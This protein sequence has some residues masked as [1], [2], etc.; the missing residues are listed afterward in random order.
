MHGA[1]RRRVAREGMRRRK[2][3]C[4]RASWCGPGTSCL[5]ARITR[6]LCPGDGPGLY[7]LLDNDLDRR[8]GWIRASACTRTH[9]AF[10][11]DE[12]FV[13]VFSLA[14]V[15]VVARY[16]IDERQHR[17][18]FFSLH[19]CCRGGTVFWS[20]SGSTRLIISY[21]ERVRGN[22]DGRLPRFFFIS[23]SDVPFGFSLR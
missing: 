2:A 12:T 11:Y 10:G 1:V 13:F 7:F 16:I 9:V 6:I 17:E 20:N 8:M 18:F 21:C 23:L 5:S 15:G 19:P 22:Q 4:R 14:V 3:C